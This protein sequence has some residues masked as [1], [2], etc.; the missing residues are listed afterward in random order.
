MEMMDSQSP[1]QSK[2]ELAAKES[3]CGQEAGEVLPILTSG[4]PPEPFLSEAPL[5][6]SS[7]ASCSSSTYCPWAML[8]IPWLIT[9]CMS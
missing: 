2:E 6:G 9:T 3:M 8:S 5:P 4:R 1:F 7:L